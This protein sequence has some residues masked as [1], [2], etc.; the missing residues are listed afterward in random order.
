M[1]KVTQVQDNDLG[2]TARTAWNQAIKTVEIGAAMTGDGTVGS[3][4]NVDLL[5]E[6]DMA[7]DSSTKAATQQSIKAY[8]DSAGSSY[9][10]T[11][12]DDTD[13][14]YTLLTS[15]QVVSCDTTSG[16]IT[17][18]MIASASF[19]SFPY[20]H[21]KTDGSYDVTIDPNGSETIATETTLDL[22]PGEAVKVYSTG[23]NLEYV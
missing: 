17:I 23:T 2:I 8:V 11:S 19:A 5:D 10:V 21:N 18:N 1:A 9:T 12:I 7:S 22:M 4:L 3:A 6:D 16:A 20:I 15:D 13:S 14:P